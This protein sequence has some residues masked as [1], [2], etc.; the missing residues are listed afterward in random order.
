MIIKKADSKKR[1]R[2][3]S[4]KASCS[5]L[6]YVY[7]NSYYDYGSDICKSWSITQALLN[8]IHRAKDNKRRIGLCYL[9]Q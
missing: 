3:S 5:D 9:T 4:C 8:L 2:E 6:Y 7:R 1:R